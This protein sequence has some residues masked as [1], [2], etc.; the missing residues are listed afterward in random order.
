[1][2]EWTVA[3]QRRTGFAFSALGARR[4]RRPAETGCY[5]RVEIR[6]P[7]ISLTIQRFA[8]LSLASL[9]LATGSGQAPATDVEPLLQ[10]QTQELMDAVAAGD[11]GPWTRYLHDQVLYAAEDGST[12]TKVQLLDELRPLPKNVWGKL[13]VTRFRAVIHGGTAI[14][15]YVAEEDEG[16]YGQ[17][18]HARY[19]STDTW[20]T[21]PDGWRLI[22][23]HITALRDDPPAVTLPASKLDDYVGVYTLTAD[24]T[25]TI[26]RGPDGL[27][28]ERTGRKPE[29]L[30]VEVPDCLFVPGQPRLRK[31][32][33]RDAAG[34]I[35]GFVERRETWDIA[36]HRSK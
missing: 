14:T 10:R 23:T 30:K 28:G 8:T 36:W 19:L 13:R 2:G 29:T 11:H 7:Y 24:L 21:S 33:Q 5:R 20:I 9:L 25:Y 27:T 6:M 22:A 15:S 35:T 3:G 4:S 12:K 18:I 26:R 1:M 32:F 31:I 16:Y 17:T 34:R